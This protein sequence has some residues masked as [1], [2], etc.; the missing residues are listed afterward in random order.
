[1][2]KAELTLLP[3]AGHLPWLD[4]PRGVAQRVHAYLSRAVPGEDG[5]RL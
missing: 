1:M 3:E 4:D 5:M 2:P